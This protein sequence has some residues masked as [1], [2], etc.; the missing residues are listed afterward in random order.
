M[1]D[2]AAGA[3]PFGAGALLRGR[4]ALPRRRGGPP[5]RAEL[6]ASWRF[7]G[8]THMRFAELAPGD[9][10]PSR[11]F[12]RP[13]PAQ[14]VALFRLEGATVGRR[15]AVFLGEDAFLLRTAARFWPE[16]AADPARRRY[17]LTP[18]GVAVGP[19]GARLIGPPETVERVETPL[20]L[21]STYAEDAY[22]HFIIDVLS[23]LHVW[24]RMPEPRPRLLV[25]REV[26]ARRRAVFEAL[27]IGPEQL[28]LKPEA[29]WIA[30]DA[31][32]A[33]DYP[34]SAAAPVIADFR[35]RLFPDGP[36]PQTGERIYLT[37]HDAFFWDRA[38]LNERALI[39]MLTAR[40]F[41]CVN[42]GD[43]DFRAQLDRLAGAGIIAGQFGGALFNLLFG[44]GGRRVLMLAS[45]N[46]TRHHLD[47]ADGALGNRVVRLRC[48]SFLARS[49]PNN[50][51]MLVDL[52]AAAAALDALEAG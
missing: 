5:A 9:D 22:T 20:F 30:A 8:G 41:R 49:D 38:V 21:L 25:S 12:P 11:P 2:E 18:H 42:L 17:V 23:R 52:D 46:Y 10:A 51:A 43:L 27:G 36:P 35:E 15:G 47:E 26:H 39:A 13:T 1:I 3:E 7:E 44:V 6:S 34:P 24:W 37:R 29:G 19:E 33:S 50:S 14:D 16:I 31:L 48:R 4:F 40:G 28:F 45:E 32:W